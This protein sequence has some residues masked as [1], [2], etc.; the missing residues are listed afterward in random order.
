M[1]AGVV[2][3]FACACVGRELLVVLRIE[4]NGLDRFPIAGRLT[5]AGEVFAVEQIL[6]RLFVGSLSEAKR[7]AHETQGR[8]ITSTETEN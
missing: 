6:H 3:Q 4:R 5:P 8:Q 2:E 7:S 1:A